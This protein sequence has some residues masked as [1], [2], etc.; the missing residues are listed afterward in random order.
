M[1]KCGEEFPKSPRVAGKLVLAEFMNAYLKVCA[2]G[3]RQFQTL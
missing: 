1:E 2:R 3:L